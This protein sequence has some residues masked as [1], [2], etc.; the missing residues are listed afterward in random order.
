MGPSRANILPSGV[1]IATSI[2]PFIIPPD[3]TQRVWTGARAGLTIMHSRFSKKSIAPTRVV[4]AAERKIAADTTGNVPIFEIHLKAG[5]PDVSVSGLLEAQSSS[6]LAR[7]KRDLV[8]PLI[9]KAGP[10]HGLGVE[11]AD[12]LGINPEELRDRP[13]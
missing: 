11:D 12:G 9:G 3:M 6:Y 5:A 8:C 4:P 7:R 10:E 2:L 1:L 13:A